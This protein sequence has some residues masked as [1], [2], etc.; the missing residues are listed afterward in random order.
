MATLARAVKDIQRQLAGAKSLLET[1]ENFVDKRPDLNLVQ[2]YKDMIPV[3][4]GRIMALEGAL[5]LL[6]EVDL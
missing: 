3:T 6:D 1:A 2:T 5:E 4:K